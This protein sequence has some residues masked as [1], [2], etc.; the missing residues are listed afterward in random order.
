MER[1]SAVRDLI[2]LFRPLVERE[3][4]ELTAASEAT[5][6]ARAPVELDQQSV[7][8]LSRMDAMQAREL[9]EESER[10]RRTR[11]VRLSAALSRMADGSFGECQ[12]CGEMIAEGP[13]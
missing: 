9:A 1:Q 8:R 5:A 11:M 2:A 12:E 7:G 6:A 4:A 10:R 3:L 13:L